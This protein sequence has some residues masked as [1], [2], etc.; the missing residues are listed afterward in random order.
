MELKD[1]T[2]WLGIE[3]ADQEKFKE[4][5]SKKYHTWQHSHGH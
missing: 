5:F 2:S 3:A 1:V 4:E